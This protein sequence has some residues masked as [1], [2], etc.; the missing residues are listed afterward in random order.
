MKRTSL[1]GLLIAI[2]MMVP[3]IP[4]AEAGTTSNNEQAAQPEVEEGPAIYDNV[5]PYYDVHDL[6]KMGAGT[7]D[8]IDV[9]DPSDPMAS[10]YDLS[11]YKR[12]DPPT[13]SAWAPKKDEN[14]DFS[15]LNRHIVR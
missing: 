14:D 2:M 11:W 5:E 4:F 15:L 7:L 9:K 3:L 8:T 1:F 12:S 13:R 6:V 10:F